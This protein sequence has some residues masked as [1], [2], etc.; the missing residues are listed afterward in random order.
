MSDFDDKPIRSPEEDILGFNP[1]A[2][3]IADSISRMEEP[4]GTVIS[5][6]GP[7]GS[8]K[9]SVVNLVR[10]HCAREQKTVFCA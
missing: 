1:L 6:N 9:S 8:G 3:V 2:K 5:I 10:H 4:E 7:W